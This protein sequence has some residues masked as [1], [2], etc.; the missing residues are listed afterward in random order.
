MKIIVYSCVTQNYNSIINDGRLYVPPVYNEFPNSPRMQA[1]MPKILPHKFLPEHDY[2]I[3]I[4]GSMTLK[5]PSEQV[6]KLFG[7]PECGVYSHPWNTTIQQ[8]MADCLKLKLDDPKNLEYHK[9]K[10]GALCQC[11]LIVRKNTDNV[12]T[13]NELWW[14]EILNGSSRDQLSFP[15]TLGKIATIRDNTKKQIYKEV[16]VIHPHLKKRQSH[17]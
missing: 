12:R 15:Y 8:E 14:N 4:D 6:I 10:T 1:K 2:S 9:E 3:W 17:K 11:G 7:Y 16:C 13:H 5:I